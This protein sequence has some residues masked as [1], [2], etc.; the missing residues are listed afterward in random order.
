MK[1]PQPEDNILTQTAVSMQ[2]KIEDGEVNY[3]SNSITMDYDSGAI[4]IYNRFTALI[5][6]TTVD[7]VGVLVESMCRI[8]GFVG[9]ISPIINKGTS[10][11]KWENDTGTEHKFL[12]PNSY[13]VP[14][15][16]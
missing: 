3:Y 4:G 13:R 12:I 9:K 6:H 10:Q 8:K 7:F 5:L 11:W 14:S 1:N 16:K 15:G 2:S